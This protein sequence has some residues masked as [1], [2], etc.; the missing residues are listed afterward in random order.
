MPNTMH[1]EF[2]AIHKDTGERALVQVKT[3][4]TPLVTDDWNRFREK[5]FLFQAH[6]IYH[7]FPAENVVSRSPK[8]IEEFMEANSKIMPG[9]VQRW[10]DFARRHQNR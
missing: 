7:G 6:G 3:G 8:T 1:Y 5:V 9:V 4:S 10:L 2:V